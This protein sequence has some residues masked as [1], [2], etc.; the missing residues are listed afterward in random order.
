MTSRAALVCG[1]IAADDIEHAGDARQRIA[2]LMGQ[3]CGQFS[4]GGEVLG[5]RHLR[6]VQAVDFFAAGFQLRHHVVEVAAQVADLVIAVGE[7]HRHVHVAELHPR[8]LVLQFHHGAANLHRQ[9]HDHRHADYERSA[10][11]DG[12]YVIARSGIER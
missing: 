11:G 3:S 6:L 2:N 4:E 1:Q 7:A 5:A 10:G 9:H 12:D 8:D